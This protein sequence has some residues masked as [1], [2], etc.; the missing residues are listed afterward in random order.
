VSPKARPLW[1]FRRQ[2]RSTEFRARI[3][4]FDVRAC[5]YLSAQSFEKKVRYHKN[6]EDKTLLATAL[7]PQIEFGLAPASTRA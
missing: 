7:S 4:V 1:G 6:D 2:I 5:D 3:Y